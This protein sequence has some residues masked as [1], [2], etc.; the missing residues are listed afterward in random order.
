[1]CRR[2]RSSAS[3]LACIRNVNNKILSCSIRPKAE[4]DEGVKGMSDRQLEQACSSTKLSQG[5]A[6]WAF[7][8]SERTGFGR[9]IRRRALFPSCLPL[10]VA[11]DHY[12]D[13]LVTMRDNELNTRANTYLTWNHRKMQILRQFGVRAYHV[14]HPWLSLLKRISQS[15]PENDRHGTLIFWPHSNDLVTPRVELHSFLADVR[16]LGESYE[17]FVICLM[18]HDVDA[19]LHKSL[20]SL[21]IPITTAGSVTSQN[22]PRKFLGLV[23][24]FRYTAGPNLGSHVFY[25]L[26]M[27]IP[28]RLVGSMTLHRG[29]IDQ[30]LGI[31][32]EFDDLSEDYPDPVDRREIEAL[33]DLLR[34]HHTTVPP[35]L[36]HFSDQQMGAGAKISRIRF[37]LLIWGAFCRDPLGVARVYS[38]ALSRKS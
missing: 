9:L 37:A 13:P 29:Q 8:E 25:S 22:F 16:Q 11:S 31:G 28:Y 23:S 3:R 4:I 2:R 14:R 36:I 26:S 15:V 12:V 21:G 19:G 1:M 17:P 5:L 24:R 20:R 33:M 18:S 35:N 6:P 27:G 10:M 30:D 38:R 34:K 7:W 32:E